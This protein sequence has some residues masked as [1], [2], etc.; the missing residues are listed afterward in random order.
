MLLSCPLCWCLGPRN[1]FSDPRHTQVDLRR[2]QISQ[3]VE[4]VQKIIYHLTAEISHQ[5]SRFQAV[6]ASNTY[7]DSIKVSRSL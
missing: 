3:S 7:N 5:D 6:P 2:Q 4:E 1:C